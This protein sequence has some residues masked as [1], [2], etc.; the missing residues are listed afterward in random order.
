VQR[1][2]IGRRLVAEVLAWAGRHHRERVTLT[3]FTDVAWNAPFYARL[4]FS[5]LPVG[6]WTHELRV[7]WER[8]REMG[9]PMEERVVM[10]APVP[11]PTP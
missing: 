5:V 6:S 8:E 4:G 2:G 11:R 1:W 7:V 10:T 9:L 3:T